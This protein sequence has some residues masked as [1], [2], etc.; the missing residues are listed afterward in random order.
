MYL[1]LAFTPTA[2]HASHGLSGSR[3]IRCLTTPSSANLLY[4]FH[5]DNSA[6]ASSMS[7]P[8]HG[9]FCL[10]MIQSQC[11]ADLRMCGQQLEL[12]RISTHHLW[13]CTNKDTDPH[14][15][16]ANYRSWFS[17]VRYFCNLATAYD[18][19]HTA[20]WFPLMISKKSFGQSPTLC[21]HTFLICPKK[22]KHE[23]IPIVKHTKHGK[24][25]P[26]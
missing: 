1:H 25:D 13:S 17:E 16:S 4:Y 15:Q 23:S 7:W 10:P 12:N 24:L 18:I 11:I 14:S 9:L 5:H 26:A 6:L 2:P 3:L 22:S 21:F 19:I 8:Q 20:A